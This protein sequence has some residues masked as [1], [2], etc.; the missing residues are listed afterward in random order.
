M[1]YVLFLLIL[2]DKDPIFPDSEPEGLDNSSF[3]DCGN[4]ILHSNV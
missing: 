1:V 2:L 4:K 3:K